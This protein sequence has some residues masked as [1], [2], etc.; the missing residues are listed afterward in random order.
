MMK[1]HRIVVLFA[2]GLWPIQSCSSSQQGADHDGGTRSGSSGGSL[3]ASSGSF[4]S[5]GSLG[6]SGSPGATGSS[7]TSGTSSGMG[8]SGV[9]SGS[10][11]SSSLD[12][13]TGSGGSGGV[14]GSTGGVCPPLVTTQ[15]SFVNLSPPGLAQAA[16]FDPS[17]NDPVP[18]A[19]AGMS[20]PAGWNFYNFPSA[21]CRDGSPLGIY[22]RTGSVNKLMI[23]MEGGGV[24]ISPHFCDHNPANMN[25]VFPGGSLNGESFAGSLVVVSGL[26][27]PYTDGIFDNT[28]SANPFLNWNQV[29]IPYCTGDGHFGTNA[30][31]S[32]QDDFGNPTTQYFVGY[33]NMQAFVGRIVATFKN[34][35]QVVLTGSS[36]GGLGAG[37]NFG[38]VQ[39][40]F[41]KVPVTLID[42]SF[43]PFTGT[44]DITPCLQSLANGLWNFTGALPSDCAACSDPDGGFSNIVPYWLQKYPQAHLALVSSIYDQIIRLFLAAGTNNC[45]DTDPNLLSGLGLQGG[46]VPD[47]DGGQYSDGLMTLRSEYLCTNRISSYFIGPADQ[48]ASDSNGS[49]ET[50]H[51]HIF[52]PRFY[53]ALAGPGQ[54]TLA[55]WVSDVVAGKVEQVGP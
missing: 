18:G 25:Q 27:A 45:S 48:D 43:P 29:Y 46:D 19:D 36:A 14:D 2:L 54:P 7:G 52:R 49:I 4:G 16:P 39:D 41:G 40:A 24:C 32:V 10:S 42:D 55:Q 11:G 9:S 30:N 31:G 23:Y 12:G 13:G 17:E 5:S 22:V 8:S 44:D 35:D 20:G 28:N 47:F 6:S 1:A 34:V 3:D 33:K 21:M 37:L 15:S 53:E 51:E 26:Q 50:L 38:M